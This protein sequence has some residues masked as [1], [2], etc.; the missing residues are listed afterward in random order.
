M[1]GGLCPHRPG[2]PPAA[3]SYMQSKR[4]VEGLNPLT[5]TP[6][7]GMTNTGLEDLADPVRVCVTWTSEGVEQVDGQ[8]LPRQA[9]LEGGVGRGSA[10]PVRVCVSLSGSPGR[11]WVS[12]QVHGSVSRACCGLGMEARSAGCVAH[13]YSAG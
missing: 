12:V 11:G 6:A 2:K 7:K 8:L 4:L 5:S 10:R 3:S 9:G 13:I 1:M